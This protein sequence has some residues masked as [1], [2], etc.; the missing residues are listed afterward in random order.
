MDAERTEKLQK[1]RQLNAM[2]RKGQIVFAGSSLAEQF[3]VNELLQ[4]LGGGDIVYN[5]G[6]SGDT[7]RDLIGS[8]EECV[9][10]LEPSKIFLNIGTNDMNER[11]SQRQLLDNYAFI[12]ER[13]KARL[14]KT[15][16]YVLAY[17]PVTDSIR[18]E[19]AQRTNEAIR[20]ANEKLAEMALNFGYT[21]VDVHSVLCKE[22]R[23]LRDDYTSDG[24]HLLPNAYLEVLK[25]LIGYFREE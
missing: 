9:F 19:F 2:A 4:T 25:I 5:R 8:L 6:I 3:P 12:L 13:M 11:Y 7:S 15:R 21:Y 22:D 16:V 14:P 17:Y 10:A 24:V 1:Y 20:Q 23:A 18:S